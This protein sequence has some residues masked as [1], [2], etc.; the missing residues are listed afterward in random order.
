VAGGGGEQ[1][2]TVLRSRATSGNPPTAAQMLGYDIQDWGAL[3]VAGNLDELAAKE[4]W[5]KVI[6]AALQNFSKYDGHWIAAPVNI[7]STNWMWASK[8]AF[9]KAGITE[10]PTDW[11]SLIAALDKLKAAGITPIAHGGQPWQDAT[12]FEAVVVSTGGPEFYKKALNDFDPEALGSDTMKQVFDRMTQLRG[13]FDENFSGRDWNLSS[14]MVMEGQAGIQ[15]MGDWAKGEFINAGKV[16]GQDFL[17]ARF[18]GTQGTVLF[19]ADQFVM[20]GVGDEKTENQTKLASAILSPEF[21]IAFNKVK[22][23]VPARTDISDAEFDDC[24]KKGM[25][26]LAEASEKGTLYG[27]LAHGH[28][29][30]AA[31]KNAVYDVVTRHLN[32]DIAT[33]EEAVTALVDAVA[34]AQ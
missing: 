5:D 22:G 31:V 25:K 9:D 19:N 33:S 12:V 6:P 4:G 30:P 26:D 1:A 16:P 27:S 23:S 17:C 2:M 7:H 14:S 10:L 34:A 15:F 29:A 28:G 21:Q 8:E 13:Y 24:A 18:P 20:F 3:G 32:G 11:D